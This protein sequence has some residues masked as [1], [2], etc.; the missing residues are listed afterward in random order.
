MAA[1]KGSSGKDLNLL[2]E[3]LGKD[4]VS[5]VHRLELENQRLLQELE[6][7]R[8]GGKDVAEEA[9]EKT[10]KIHASVIKLEE[11]VRKIIVKPWPQT[12]SPKTPFAQPQLSPNKFK[13]PISPKGPGADLKSKKVTEWSPIGVHQ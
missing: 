1:M 5:R 11:Q 9:E 12:H 13:D 2:S 10:K 7:A 3:Q 6:E 4:A 8:A